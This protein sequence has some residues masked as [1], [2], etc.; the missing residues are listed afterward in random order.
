MAA[1]KKKTTSL[2]LTDSVLLLRV[3][4]VSKTSMWQHVDGDLE[5]VVTACTSCTTNVEF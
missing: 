3:I 2:S 5:C 1:I 4:F